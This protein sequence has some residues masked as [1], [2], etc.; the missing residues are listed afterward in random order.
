[1]ILTLNCGSSSLKHA[2][3]D[4][5]TRV[6]G[7]ALEIGEDAHQTHADAAQQLLSD[8]RARNGSIDAVA[9]RLVHGGPDHHSPSWLTPDLRESLRGYVAFAPLHLP[10][11]LDAIEAIA[12][13]DPSLK[14]LACF[15][16]DFHW[17][18]PDL[19]RRLPIPRDLHDQGL[20][21][22]GFHGLSY[23][24]IQS[25]LRER[26]GPRTIIAHLGSGSSLVALN[27]GWPIDTTMS[28]TPNSGVTSGTRSG[29][30]DPGIVFFL[31]RRGESLDAIESR[32]EHGS[33]LRGISETSADM[34]KLLS[35]RALDSRA[36]LAVDIYCAEVR[37]A[38]G[39]LAAA[40]GGLDTL[41]FTGGIGAH[42]REVR[43]QI[44]QG[45]EFLSLRAEAVIAV[46]TDEERVLARR[47][48]DML[49]ESRGGKI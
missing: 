6:A 49:E 40:L 16:T 26:L 33:G 24:F 23:E 13:R 2:L 31:A 39:A 22:Y 20:R 34:R 38:I 47:A 25:E 3:F 14:Q 45:L 17:G 46:P 41:I 43:E 1:M 28:F 37:K 11:A 36:R 44:L 48:R 8:L 9:H 42:A 7:G 27:Q 21:R 10:P 4:G 32:L 29:S 15:D 19:A 12:A 30:I 18:L 5:E 35:L